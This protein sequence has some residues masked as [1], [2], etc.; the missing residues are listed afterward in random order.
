M[1]L[2]RRV[3]WLAVAAVLVQAP[4]AAEATERSAASARKCDG[5]PRSAIDA[6][7]KLAI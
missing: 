1:R 7:K 5:L 2:S 4:L 6:H 3:G